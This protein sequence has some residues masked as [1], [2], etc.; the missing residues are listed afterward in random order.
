MRLRYRTLCFTSYGDII[1]FD[2]AMNAQCMSAD[3]YPAHH[4]LLSVAKHH[5]CRLEA[6]GAVIDIATLMLDIMGR[7][8]E[9]KTR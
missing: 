9:W 7:L 4:E 2:T 8:L 3:E 1:T 5:V 6:V